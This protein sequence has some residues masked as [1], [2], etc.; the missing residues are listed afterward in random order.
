MWTDRQVERALFSW[1]KWRRS[2]V[3]QWLDV[4]LGWETLSLNQLRSKAKHELRGLEL[5]PCIQMQVYWLCCAVSDYFID[6][7]SSYRKICMPDWL[8]SRYSGIPK[9][10]RIELMHAGER[11]YPPAVWTAQEGNIGVDADRIDF[12]KVFLADS[13][14]TEYPT[15]SFPALQDTKDPGTVQTWE[16]YDSLSLFS[17]HELYWILKELKGRPPERR[18][19]RGREACYSDR[20]AVRCA[21]LKDKTSMSDYEIALKFNLPHER[22]WESNQSDTVRHLVERGRIVLESVGLR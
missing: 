13:Q 3:L 16:I 21:L 12:P 14:D 10:Y 6:D 17:D 4:D 7:S 5:M 15:N 2:I 22:Y 20:W 1:V 9:D 8:W 18:K 11:V 19:K